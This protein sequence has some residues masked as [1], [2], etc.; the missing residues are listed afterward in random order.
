MMRSAL[1][2]KTLIGHITEAETCYV[3]NYKANWFPVTK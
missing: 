3:R 1:I 2:F